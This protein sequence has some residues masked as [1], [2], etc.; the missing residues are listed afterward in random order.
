ME[1]NLLKDEICSA[2]GSD[3]VK[4][5]N[6]SFPIGRVLFS[7]VKRD[8]NGKESGSIDCYI[9]FGQAGDLCQQIL[10]G[11]LFEKIGN[12]K[13]GFDSGLGGVSE[14]DC[15][16]RELRTDGKAIS[17]NFKI[18]KSSKTS[19]D[20][21]FTATQCAGKTDEN[22]LIVPCGKAEI[23]VNIPLTEKKLREMAYE[24]DLALKGFTCYLYTTCYGSFIEDYNKNFRGKMA[25]SAPDQ[26]SGQVKPSGQPE[27]GTAQSP[28]MEGDFYFCTKKG[29]FSQIRGTERNP[30]VAIR[31]VTKKITDEDTPIET[32]D[33]FQLADVLF[34]KNRIGAYRDEYDEL[35]SLIADKREL[36]KNVGRYRCQVLDIK[37][38]VRQLIFKEKL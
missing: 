35:L 6:I 29:C 34:Y 33:R 32:D 2:W 25:E 36:S 27:K 5:K 30:V 9:T 38:G 22:G 37:D 10:S 19:Y 26:V 31:L 16:S 13:V 15:K 23:S 21:C 20:C 3:F 18:Q 11:A 12:G 7:F 1:K 14:E 28:E 8:R 4:V 24:I 17:R